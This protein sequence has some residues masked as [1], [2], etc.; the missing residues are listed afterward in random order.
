MRRVIV[1][2][3]ALLVFGIVLA[4]ALENLQSV[5]VSYLF[6]TATMPLAAILA[7]VLVIGV[8]VGALAAMPAV[9]R[10]RAQARR[11]R[12]ELARAEEEIGNL[13]RAPL[14]DAR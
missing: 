3:F 7:T 14:R 4:L 9:L 11:N 13:R 12:N 6:G 10:A 1:L 2:I 5:A 8:L